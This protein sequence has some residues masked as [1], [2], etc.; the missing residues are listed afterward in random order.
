MARFGAPAAHD[1]DPLRAVGAALAIRDW[2]REEEDLQV[3]IAADDAVLMSVDDP[4]GALGGGTSPDE[5]RRNAQPR[6]GQTLHQV[7]GD[8]KSED[9]LAEVRRLLPGPAD[10]LFIDGDHTYAG[11]KADYLNYRELVRPG[12]LIGF[13]DI[14]PHPG[15]ADCE[16][17][18]LWA[19]IGGRKRE[20]VSPQETRSDLGGT[21]GGIGIVRAYD[22]RSA[23]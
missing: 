20:I 22:N 11:V 14:L 12:G 23:A 13:H 19:E 1:D 16:V 21:W 4:A 15:V 17:D 2:A 7:L 8:S 10:V 6:D 5:V 3:R 9:V 18:R